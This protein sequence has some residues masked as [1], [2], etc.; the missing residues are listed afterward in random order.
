MN[1]LPVMYPVIVEGKYDKIK[2]DSLLDTTVIATDGFGVF[3]DGEKQ[4]LFRALAQKDRVIVLTDPDGAGRLIRSFLCGF[5]P[6]DRII[7]L[8]VPPVKGV[9][10]RKSSPSK[11][12]LLGVEGINAD[13]IRDIF[14]PFCAEREPVRAVTKVDL[15]CDGLSGREESAARRAALCRTL[16]LPRDIS[17]DALLCYIN[18]LYGYDRYTELI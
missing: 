4:A 3:R 14:R 8:Y 7:N 17:A 18:L 12:G 5:I 6:R 16:G 9:E 15:Y 10:K 13:I 11:A 1:K 2:L